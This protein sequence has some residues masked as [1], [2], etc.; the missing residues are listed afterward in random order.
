[1]QCHKNS[2]AIAIPTLPRI[3]KNV[4]WA[5]MKT[6][7]NTQYTIWLGANPKPTPLVARTTKSLFSM[8]GLYSGG[9]KLITSNPSFSLLLPGI[10]PSAISSALCV[11]AGSYPMLAIAT[12]VSP[13][14]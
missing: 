13:L 14:V 9:P 3:I 1:M 5:P 12:T 7:M 10:L 2:V 11:M 8:P 6:P 4:I